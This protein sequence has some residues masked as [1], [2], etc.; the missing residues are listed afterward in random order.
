MEFR[1]IDTGEVDAF[2][3]ALAN[4]FG[5]VRPEEDELEV[6]RARLERDRTWA[7]VEDGRIVG[8]AGAYTLRTVVPGGATVPTAGLTTVGVLPTHRR[9]GITTELLARILDQAVEREEPFTTLFASQAAIYGRFGYGL[10]TQALQLDVQLDRVRFASGLEPSGRVR[11]RTREEALPV[12]LEIYE[13]FAPTTQGS[14]SCDLDTLSWSLMEKKDEPHFYA[15]HEDDAGTPDAFAVY[16]TKHEWPESLPHVELKLRQL[17]ATSAPASHSMWRYLFDVDLVSRVT[18]EDRPIDEPLLWQLSEPRAARPRLY[19][20]L[21]ARPLDVDAALSTRGYA[22]DG[23][24]AIAVR[25][26]FRPAT[27]GVYELIVDGGQAT[28]S[29]TDRGPDLVTDVNALGSTYL[30]AASW[31]TLARAG[32]AHG[33]D[34]ALALADRLFA[35][36]VA[37]WAPFFF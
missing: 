2:F 31:T 30:G 19:D 12:M 28:C 22:A 3:A 24:L 15:I 14:I 21:H 11:L 7:A 20:A 27:D 5:D 17:I 23:R 4:A 13:R 36:P 34:P 10:A 35:T 1:T 8:C 26:P 33:E 6:D 18:S 16:R 29:R 9:R 37:P 25:D 32:R